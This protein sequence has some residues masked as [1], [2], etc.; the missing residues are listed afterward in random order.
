LGGEQNMI[1]L[2]K[3]KYNLTNQEFLFEYLA[4]GIEKRNT[5]FMLP[6]MLI[7]DIYSFTFFL[8]KRTATVD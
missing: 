3:K 2:T 6:N 1:V 5:R 4:T 8:R 7:V